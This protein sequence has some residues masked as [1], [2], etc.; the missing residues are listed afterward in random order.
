MLRQSN[1]Q[2]VVPSASATAGVKPMRIQRGPAIAPNIAGGRNRRRLGLPSDGSWKRSRQKKHG[3]M[4]SNRLAPRVYGDSRLMAQPLA[5]AQAIV[6][7][8][9]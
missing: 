7:A 4:Q 8:A 1:M 3:A 5:Q 9:S 2:I 6:S